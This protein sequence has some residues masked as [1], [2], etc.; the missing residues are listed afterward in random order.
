[1][2]RFWFHVQPAEE[3][4]SVAK[5]S[6]IFNQQLVV[7][8]LLGYVTILSTTSAFSHTVSIHPFISPPDITFST[9]LNF[10]STVRVFEQHVGGM[11]H[12]TKDVLQRRR[13]RLH[14]ISAVRFHL[15]RIHPGN[16][17]HRRGSCYEF[18]HS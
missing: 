6:F 17:L 11:L 9:S 1:M 2:G 7:I 16:T 13:L 3:L 14:E 12:R 4:P 8:S 18:K 15:D 5:S 10:S